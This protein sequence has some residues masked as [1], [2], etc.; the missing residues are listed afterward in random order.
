M[1]RDVAIVALMNEE[2]KIFLVRTHDYPDKWQPVGG[3]I[4]PEDGVAEAAAVR[5]VLEETGLD[6]QASDLQKISVVPFDFG[7]GEVHCFTARV[8]KGAEFKIQQTEI[9]ESG[10]FSLV[11]AVNLPAYPATHAFLVML[12]GTNFH[13]AIL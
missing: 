6:L 8:P 13:Q 9:A 12:A 10:W 4:E 2:G 11:E 7:E 3:G 1:K 5:E